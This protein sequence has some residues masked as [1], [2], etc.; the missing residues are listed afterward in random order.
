MKKFWIICSV[1]ALAAGL[2]RGEDIYHLVKEIP[3]GGNGGWD[4]LS[5]DEAARRLYVSHGSNVVV[6]DI[7]QDKVVGEISDTPG[8]HGVAVAS[9]LKRG[10]VTCGREGKAAIVDLANLQTLTKVAT[11]ENPDGMLY[12]P[13]AHEAY[14]FNGRGQS[15]TVINVKEAKVVAT[16]PLGGKPEFGAADPEAGRVYD[17]LED[18]SEIVVI[19]T[20]THT[21]ISHWPVAPGEEPSGMAIDT[22]HHH[23]FVGCGNEKMLMVNATDGKVLAEVPIGR[24]VDATAFDPGTGLAFASCGDGTT[25]IARAEGDKLTVAQKLTTEVRAKTM[26]LDPKTHRIY[27]GSAKF[28]PPPADGEGNGRRRPRMIPGTFKIL[29]YGMAK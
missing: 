25:T 3:V 7:D 11:G 2:C 23:L 15:A 19:D 14:T 28:E 27:L 21:A 12:E 5:V 18:K 22:A 17:N 4:Y 13:G 24:G 10:V 29:V 1:T 8:V 26:T 20:K 16:I 6:I 9:D